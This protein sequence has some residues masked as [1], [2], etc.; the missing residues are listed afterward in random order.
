MCLNHGLDF[1]DLLPISK[2][3]TMDYC[4]Q[5]IV[6]LVVICIIQITCF[7][8]NDKMEKNGLHSLILFFIGNGIYIFRWVNLFLRNNCNIYKTM[9]YVSSLIRSPS[10]LFR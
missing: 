2:T 5:V 7:W 10:P 9:E 4:G 6:R 1:D 3:N 8:F